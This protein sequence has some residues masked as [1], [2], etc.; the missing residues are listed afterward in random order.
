M[1]TRMI[2]ATLAMLNRLLGTSFTAAP[3][4]TGT[5]ALVRATSPSIASPTLT[6]SVTGPDSGAWGSG[7]LSSIAAISTIGQ[8]TS[9][10][11]ID[12]GWQVNGDGCILT[13][14]N[15]ANGA[16]A[17]GSGLVM[18]CNPADGSMGLYMCGGGVVSGI[19]VSG[20]WVATTTTPGAGNASIAFASSFYRLYNNYGSSQAFKVF[21]LMARAS[22]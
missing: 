2:G 6:G 21:G 4:S 13:V 3:G 17:A 9:T 14:A 15:G 1:S 10:Y 11:D 18:V 12:S 5:G 20:T 7:G 8:L 16:F 22:V 19:Y